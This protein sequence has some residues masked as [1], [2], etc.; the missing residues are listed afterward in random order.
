MARHSAEQPPSAWL[1]FSKGKGCSVATAVPA[2]QGADRPL[3][4]RRAVPIT[5]VKRSH[6]SS[7][8]ILGASWLRVSFYNKERKREGTACNQSEFNAGDCL[9]RTNW[10]TLPALS[11]QEVLPEV[12]SSIYKCFFLS[13]GLQLR[14][15]GLCFNADSQPASH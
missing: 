6:S 9:M 2:L 10:T 15:F 8:P 7:L 4:F 12:L 13:P 1:P 14:F 5:K 11:K 3:T